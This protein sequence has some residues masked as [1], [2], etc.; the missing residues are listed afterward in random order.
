MSL[1]ENEIRKYKSSDGEMR[2]RATGVADD[3][4][5][6]LLDFGTRGVVQSTI[7]DFRDVIEVFDNVPTDGEMLGNITTAT[8]TKDDVGDQLRK[9]IGTVRSMVLN[10][11]GSKSGYYTVYGFGEISQ[12]SDSELHSLAKRCIRVATT[13]LAMTDGLATEGLTTAKIAAIEALRVLFDTKR[14]LVEAAKEARSLMKIERVAKGNAVYKVFVRLCNIGKD[15]YKGVNSEKYEE[16]LIALKH[17]PA[18]DPGDEFGDL[19]GNV[20]NSNTNVSVPDVDVTLKGPDQT[21]LVLHAG[22]TASFAAEHVL[23]KYNQ[24]TAVKYGFAPYTAAII[25]PPDG[26]IIHNIKLVPIVVVP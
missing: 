24:I 23:T 26:A 12:M 7:D 9:S 2:D 10:K 1:N 15:L 13:E 22:N 5:R 11:W 16:Y 4:E 18:V 3:A 6:D 8:Q 19:S 25:I 21:D 20:S 17:V 14:G